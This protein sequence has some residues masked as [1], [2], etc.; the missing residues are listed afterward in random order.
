MNY[1]LFSSS[2]LLLIKDDLNSRAKLDTG[3]HCNYKCGFCYYLDKLDQKTDLET[4]KS[5]ALKLRRMGMR[6]IDL[7]GGESSIHQNWFEILD[8]CR[9]LGFSSISTL[10]NGATFSNRDF[11]I[12]S[13]EHGLSEILFSLHGHDDESHAKLVG[14]KNSFEKILQ[15][16]HLARELGLKVRLNCTVTSF[17]V[18]SLKVYA[19]LVNSIL[20]A[21]MNF[22]PLNYWDAAS[23]CPSEN[24]ETLSAGIKAAIDLLNPSI[25]IN[26]RYIPFC[27][28]QGYEKY[29]VGIYQHIFDKGDW[30]IIGYDVDTW[31]KP[32][33][34]APG[35]EEYFETAKKK[36]LLTY[37]KSAECFNC[38]Y[39]NI[40][41]GVE[42]K[43][44]SHQT[45]YPVVDAESKR[46]K[47]VLYF[48]RTMNQERMH[49]CE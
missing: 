29:V 25:E 6:E 37:H 28:M 2:E 14:R 34:D 10:S 9:E 3:T 21:Q 42:H 23:E 30:N 13:K 12:K 49:D 24:Y 35:V 36:R 45:V 26:V 31:E 44:S 5:R 20:P 15:A 1:N 43:L 33:D 4:I 17:N 27:F 46:I 47:D 7:S 16:I 38:R 19:T 40:C 22:L 39:F 48:K 11:L 41:D 8:Y 18:D 32:Y